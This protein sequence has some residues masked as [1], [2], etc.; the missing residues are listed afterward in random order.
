MVVDHEFRHVVPARAQRLDHFVGQQRVAFGYALERAP[1]VEALVGEVDAAAE[2]VA[3]HRAAD[4]RAVVRRRDR[5][6]GNAV[7]AAQIDVAHVARLVRRRDRR[8]AGHLFGGLEQSVAPVA[9]PGFIFR[10]RLDDCAAAE[11]VVVADVAHH[12]LVIR[13]IHGDRVA[14][15]VA[16]MVAPRDGEVPAF[17]V[18]V[19]R[20]LI[21]G[22][23]AQIG[24]D[25]HQDEHVARGLFVVVGRD[26]QAVVE[27]ID[28]DAHVIGFGGLPGDVVE[29]HLIGREPLQGLYQT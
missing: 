28:V 16:D 20:V 6:V 8:I 4:H 22:R 14:E 9:V 3:R 15:I 11:L 23:V 2:V 10:V 7:L 25:V 27:E 13:E 19:A 17:G 26:P 24:G 12:R 1:Q 18:H 21:G 5:A 29:N